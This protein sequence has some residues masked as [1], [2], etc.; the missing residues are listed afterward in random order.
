MVRGWCT[1]ALA[2]PWSLQMRISA[3]PHMSI[4]TYG[5]RNPGRDVV[6]E[7]SG[8][9]SSQIV[10]LGVFGPYNSTHI[11]ITWYRRLGVQRSLK[12]HHFIH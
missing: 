1:C 5:M 6:C 8:P 7:I 9:L 4:V 3:R 11:Y 2:V 10:I 12:N